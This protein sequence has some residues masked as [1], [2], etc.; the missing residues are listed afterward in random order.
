MTQA[1]EEAVKPISLVA[2]ADYSDGSG[3]Y[4]FV[5]MGA[6]SGYPEGEFNLCGAAERP[7]GVMTD[8]PQQGQPSRIAI[9][10]V[11]PIILGDTVAKGGEISSGALGVGIPQASTNP[12][13]GVAVWGGVAGDIVPMEIIPQR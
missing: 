10:G 5:K 6:V 12:S 9:A 11:V 7:S 4:R 3:L 1:Y 2:G 13:F 8:K